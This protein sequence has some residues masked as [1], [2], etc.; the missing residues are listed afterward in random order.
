[1]YGN[2][3]E[4][5]K[6]PVSE[7]VWRI[8]MWN[9]WQAH[10][11]KS[12]MCRRWQGKPEYTFNFR[13]GQT[14]F[15]I[16]SWFWLRSF[17]TLYASKI[18]RVNE[19]SNWLSDR[20]TQKILQIR[21]SP[22]FTIFPVPGCRHVKIRLARLFEMDCN[23]DMCIWTFL[24]V[25]MDQYGSWFCFSK[26]VI[27]TTEA[28]T[29]PIFLGDLRLDVAWCHSQYLFSIGGVSQEHL[30]FQ[31]LKVRELSPFIPREYHSFLTLKDSYRWIDQDSF[32][33]RKQ[34]IPPASWLKAF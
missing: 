33:P 3:L 26:F 4:L 19:W 21:H 22:S 7:N 24:C 14:Y 12:R 11:I 17:C 10:Y 8:C 30:A 34:R 25:V 1:M 32:Q 6:I 29:Q 23:L 15:E 27:A 5:A 18:V 9:V 16:L 13:S 20:K 28:V 2:M 31:V